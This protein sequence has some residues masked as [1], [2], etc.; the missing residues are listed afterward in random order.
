MKEHGA[1]ELDLWI[2]VKIPGHQLAKALYEK[3]ETIEAETFEAE[4]I[5]QLNRAVAI[6]TRRFKE[7][8]PDVD[9]AQ[10]DKWM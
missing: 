7:K 3:A 4:S 10:I 9:L 2:K 5:C 8:F 1:L 6:I